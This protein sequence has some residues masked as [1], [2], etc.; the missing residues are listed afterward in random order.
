[1]SSLQWLPPGKSQMLPASLGGSP[2]WA[3]GYYKTAFQQVPL[4]WEQ[5]V[6]FCVIPVRVESLSY[7]LCLS[8]VQALL[9]FTAGCSRCLSCLPAA[10]LLGQGAA[11][12]LGYSRLA[13]SCDVS[14]WLSPHCGCLLGG[15]GLTITNLCPST[16]FH[17]VSFFVPFV[18]ENSFS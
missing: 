1:M 2:R 16:E 8:C 9:A 13:E 5:N 17:C 12:V 15:V 7:S 11:V 10:K 14:Q 4:C 6:R 3:S 18:A